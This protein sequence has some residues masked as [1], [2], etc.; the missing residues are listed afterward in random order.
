MSTILTSPLRIPLLAAFFRAAEQI[1]LIV[2]VLAHPVLIVVSLYTIHLVMKVWKPGD[3]VPRLG[4]PVVLGY[5]WPIS[6]VSY[7]LRS[8]RKVHWPGIRRVTVLA[9]LQAFAATSK[10]LGAA[11]LCRPIN[12]KLVYLVHL[13]PAIT[14]VRV[15]EPRAIP[16]AMAAGKRVGV[17]GL[18][19]W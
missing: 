17:D 1:P 19:A 6:F 18:L 13:T 9:R 5:F 7:V 4:A 15:G 12:L 10:M 2:A 16:P 8:A 14:G 3:S 11:L